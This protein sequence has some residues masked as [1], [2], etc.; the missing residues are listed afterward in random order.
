MAALNRKVDLKCVLL[1]RSAVGKS[2]LVERFLHD[3]WTS[4]QMPTVGAAFGA[5][6]ITIDKKKVTLGIWDTAGSER[7]ES[8][9]RHYYKGAEAAVICYDLTDADSWNKVKFWV[10]E[11]LAYEENCLIAL[12]GTK[13]DLVEG[14]IT[15]L[16]SSS[17]TS[18]S[19]ASSGG[20]E[21]RSN[22][23]LKPRGVPSSVVRQYAVT[24]NAKCYETSALT[25]TGVAQPFIELTRD[26]TLRPRRAPA[27]Y[28]PVI[29]LHDSTHANGSPA[30]ANTRRS[31]EQKS[32]VCCS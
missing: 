3:R 25:S 11:I 2:C 20:G 15:A 28:S 16:S 22:V 26:F 6:E 9:T 24:I 10:K 4:D 8:M 23:E 27:S 29:S 13:L 7:Y 1:G 32:G 30:H 14:G 31:K 21:R 5:K 18:P 12:V 19:T 17:P